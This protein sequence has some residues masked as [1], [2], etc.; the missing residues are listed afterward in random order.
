MSVQ[1]RKIQTDCQWFLPH[2]A[3]KNV[4]QN[5]LHLFVCIQQLKGLLHL[6][7]SS[8]ASHV[9]EICRVAAFQLKEKNV[10]SNFL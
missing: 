2:Y 8:S 1:T 9:Q 10:Y 5:G 4:D 6:T 3:S 7:L